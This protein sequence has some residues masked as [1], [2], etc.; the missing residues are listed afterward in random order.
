MIEKPKQTLG[1]GL[2]HV[3]DDFSVCVE[4]GEFGAAGQAVDKEEGD[5]RAGHH[6][7]FAEVRRQ[8]VFG[9]EGRVSKSAAHP[10]RWRMDRR[11]FIWGFHGPILWS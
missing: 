6:P 5:G 10:F 7:V 3:S 4:C 2:V 8:P 9:R 1:R 11:L